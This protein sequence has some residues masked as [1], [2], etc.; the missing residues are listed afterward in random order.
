MM[1][2]RSVGIVLAATSLIAGPLAAQNECASVP[3]PQ[4]RQDACQAAA[5]AMK[6]FHPTL[7]ILVSG[8]NPVIGVAG[9]RGGFPHLS[10]SFRVNIAKVTLPNPDSASASSV[11]AGFDGL[12]P[13][14]VV[15]ATLGVFPGMSGGIL[16]VDI[17]TSAS[18]LPTNQVDNLTVDSS[19]TSIGDI[20]L[21]LGYGLR[22]GVIKGAF[23]IPSVSVSV[24]RRSLPR[25]TYGNVNGGDQMEF[26]TDLKATNIRVV[27]GIR[28]L[29]VDVAA[30]FGWDT[31]TSDAYVAFDD[32]TVPLVQRSQIDLK[33]DN[34]RSVLFLNAG[35]NL[36]VLKV[37]AE[38]GAQSGTDDQFSTN[39][40]GFDP[41]SGKTFGALGVRF[42]F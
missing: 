10:A 1:S 3:P 6:A 27:A 9:T 20:A 33:L 36:A 24:M 14:P 16:S 38:I 42:S 4:A 11:P 8:G 21:G 18:L 7:G 40:R 15:E 17:L 39:F 22:V 12:A 2:F 30:G 37:V 5:D 26:S 31:Y 19:A 25:L 23:P 13:A 28:L 29:L 32:P 34:S 41:R 35:L